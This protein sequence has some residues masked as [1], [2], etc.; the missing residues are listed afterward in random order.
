[1]ISTFIKS[2]Y[3]ILLLFTYSNNTTSE[4]PLKNFI[5]SKFM[6]H[7]LILIPILFTLA[8]ISS[9]LAESNQ[10]ELTSI[11]ESPKTILKCEP[12]LHSGWHL[13]VETGSSRD[14]EKKLALFYDDSFYNKKPKTTST[15]DFSLLGLKT[16]SEIMSYFNSRTMKILLLDWAE[17]HKASWLKQN[18]NDESNLDDDSYITKNK[19]S[20]INSIKELSPINLSLKSH[21]EN[22][23]NNFDIY[24]KN[25]QTYEV[26]LSTGPLTITDNT[27]ND[28]PSY[29]IASLI[30]P[31]KLCINRLIFN[32]EQ[33]K[34]DDTCINNSNDFDNYL[35]WE[36]EDLNRKLK[37]LMD[38][39]ISI[40]G[41]ETKSSIEIFKTHLKSLF[42]STLLNKQAAFSHQLDNLYFLDILRDEV[43]A[44]DEQ[45][46]LST[47]HTID[48]INGPQNSNNNNNSTKE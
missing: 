48:S 5:N 3:C 15:T 40:I 11:F 4:Y 29:Q 23:I 17:S 13:E 34:G 33:L 30:G 41:P 22:K 36:T 47:C 7:N 32:E 35:T 45:V 26:F 8:F 46:I 44:I 27:S 10:T 43:S 6:V 28:F 9:A 1:M 20:Y 18:K 19:E 14:D 2:I 31:Y 12:Y 37:I 21:I 24:Q 38:S 39:N 25:Q 16:E 42:N